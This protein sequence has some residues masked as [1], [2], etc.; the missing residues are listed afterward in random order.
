MSLFDRLF[1]GGTAP[2]RIEP[3]FQAASPENP[4]TNLAD[5][6]SWLTDWTSGGMSGSFGPPVSERT[7]MTVSA[8][9]RSVSILSGLIASLPLKV[10]KRSKDGRE[11]ASNHR[12]Q[13]MFQV[14]PY[15]GRPMTSF[16]W[17]ELWGINELLWGDHFSAIRYDG[18]ARI[19][20]FETAM[21][22]DTEVY[23]INN[24]NKYRCVFWP[25]GVTGND[26]V[27][28]GYRVEW[29]D[30]DDMIHIPGPGFN[31]I[32]GLSR[33]RANA[34]NSIALSMMLPEQ[35]GRTHENAARP[36]GLVEVPTGI[37]PEGFKKFR[38]QFNQNNTG[39]A[40]VGKVIYGDPGT[41]F[42]AFQLTPEDLN[43]IELMR[44]EVADVSRFFGVPLPLLNET[45][46]STSWG[47]G[48]SEQ[49]LA[50]LIFTL[51]PDLGRIESELNYKLFF[52]SEY[53]VEFDRAGL[54]AMDPVKAAEVAQ[55]EIQTGTLLINEYRKAK[56]RPPVDNGDLPLVNATMVPLEKLYAPGAQPTADPIGIE[57]SPDPEPAPS[58]A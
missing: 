58:A 22:W 23:R 25:G 8:V 21:P 45:T 41:K 7:A 11:D 2:E 35:I 32:R 33:I 28:S 43:T 5:P 10:Y 3:S 18:A 36:S 14:A 57:T 48:L 52:G 9:Y 42:T 54:M 19:I 53:Y 20:G 55:T 16:V 4:T 13:P 17:R 30:Q 12:L 24:R 37:D 38:A 50:F 6:A 56:N 40:N 51:E 39:R 31:G 47:T 46:K 49:N 1:G 26:E 34:R 44:Y 29:I 15:P 27:G